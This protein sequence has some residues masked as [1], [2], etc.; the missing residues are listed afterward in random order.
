MCSGAAV[1]GDLNTAVVN[2]SPADDD[3]WHVRSALRSL[4]SEDRTRGTE[5]CDGVFSLELREGSSWR[6]ELDAE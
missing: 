1:A 4:A 6:R 2:V 5:M 3:A